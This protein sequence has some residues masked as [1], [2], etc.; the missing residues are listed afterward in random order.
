MFM[1]QLHFSLVAAYIFSSDHQSLMSIQVQKV[2]NH[3]ICLMLFSSVMLGSICKFQKYFHA[4]IT[5]QSCNSLYFF[6][7]PSEFDFYSSLDIKRCTIISYSLSCV[8]LIRCVKSQLS[9][10]FKNILI[11][12]LNYG[13]L[14]GYHCFDKMV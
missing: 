5:F 8:F 2:Y 4:A 7:W 11:L 14:S 13:W 1:L 3:A 6:I 12:L 10:D 9:V